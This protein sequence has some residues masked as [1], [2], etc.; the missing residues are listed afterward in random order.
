MALLAVTCL[1]ASCATTPQATTATTPQQEEYVS[2]EVTGSLLP[3]RI[4]KS[5]AAQ[6]N[7][8]V[9]GPDSPTLNQ[10]DK[11]QQLQLKK[12]QQAGSA[13]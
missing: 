8:T 4:K 6:E 7:I 11:T 10:I 12:L 3:R 1:L 9:E 13:R 5:Q 2:V